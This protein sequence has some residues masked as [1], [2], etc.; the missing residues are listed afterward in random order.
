MSFKRAK[1]SSGNV[2]ITRISVLSP[3]LPCFIKYVD[4]AG[5]IVDLPVLRTPAEWGTVLVLGEDIIPEVAY[6]VEAEDAAFNR[7]DVAEATT[8]RWGD[9]NVNTVVNI[10]DVHLGI[11]AF[12]EDF[13]LVTTERA[14]I[15]PCL[16]NRIANIDDVL[17]TILIFQGGEFADLCTVPC[18]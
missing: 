14:D 2:L 3:D 12:Q 7:S 15:I 13:T 1:L 5:F 4:A 17:R 16:P 11:K 6:F 10:N 8:D 9:A 18:E